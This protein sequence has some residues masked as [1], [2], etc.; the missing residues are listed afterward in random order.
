MNKHLRFSSK[1]QAESV[2][3]DK[4]DNELVPK[5]GLSVDVI[6][7]IN[8]PTGQS[9]TT[10][11]GVIPQVAPVSGWHVNVRGDAADKFAQYEVSVSTPA[12]DWF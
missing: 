11:E 3:F 8:K 2:L 1:S 4:I 10:S 9:I 5:F 6:G 12:R 7:V